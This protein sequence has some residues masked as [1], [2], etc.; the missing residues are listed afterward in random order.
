[1]RALL[2]TFTSMCLITSSAQA[3]DTQ[4]APYEVR[5]A[6]GKLTI[7]AQMSEMLVRAGWKDLGGGLLAVNAWQHSAPVSVSNYEMGDRLLM[8]I[9]KQD[10]SLPSDN[11][12][13]R[14]V[15]RTM[16]AITV[17]G[18]TGTEGIAYDCKVGQRGDWTPGLFA[19]VDYEL[20]ASETGQSALVGPAKVAFHVDRVDGRLT[21]EDLP[22]YCD[23]PDYG[24]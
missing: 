16:D 17:L 22:V 10:G 3:Q 6:Y 12:G 14:P 9:S 15:W 5:A 19:V 11:G 18:V 13:T 20:V 4:P 1:M 2:L 8:I 7:S 23:K 21:R 24:V